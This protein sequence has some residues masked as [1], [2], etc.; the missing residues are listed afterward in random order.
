LFSFLFSAQTYYKAS[1]PCLFAVSRFEGTT[2]PSGHKGWYFHCRCLSWR[3][4]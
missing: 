3:A 2:R 4:I 1:R